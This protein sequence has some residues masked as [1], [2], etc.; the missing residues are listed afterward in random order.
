M[1]LYVVGIFSL[2]RCLL[3]SLTQFII[4]LFLY[5]W[6]LRVLCTFWI[7]ALCEIFFCKY[8][9]PVHSLSD[10]SL[11][12][13]SHREVFNSN[14]VQ[15]INYFFLECAFGVGPKK[16]TWNPSSCRFSPM[17]SSRSFIG[18]HST[19]RCVIHFEL[20]FVKGIISVI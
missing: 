2:V 10:C 5:C 15:L 3:R 1:R 7:I 16:S 19:F 4:R 12:S 14:E 20:I 18:L 9:L 13:V 6:L 11:D 17:F 8:F